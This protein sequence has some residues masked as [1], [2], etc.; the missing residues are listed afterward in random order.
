MVVRVL[1]PA[2][3]SLRRARDWWNAR[4]AQVRDRELAVLLSVLAF[5]PGFAAIGVEFGDL[6]VRPA[7]AFAVVLVLAQTVPLA[8]RTRLPAVCLAVSGLAFVVHALLGYPETFGGVG[9]Y[10]ALYAAGAY[11]RGYRRTLPLAATGCYAV[12]SVALHL[13]GSPQRFLDF[14]VFFAALCAFWGAGSYVRR[15]RAE[16]A[17]HRHSAALAA[18]AA[19]RARIARELHDVVTHHVTAMVVQADAAQFLSEQP[20]RVAEGLVA[21]GGTGRRAL[22]EL[23][24]LLGVLEATGESAS[25]ERSPTLGTVRELVERTRLG[26][27][28]V[29]LV[30]QGEHRKLGV[31][32]ELAVYRVVQEALTNAVKHAAGQH[33]VVRVGYGGDGVEIEVMSA[34]SGP[35][36]SASGGR[37]LRGLR[38]RVAMVGGELRAG[39]GPEGGFVVH[40]LIPAAGAR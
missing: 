29:E 39:P 35:G 38:E 30:E 9:F 23:R 20:D 21:I 25:A 11:Q 40:A 34:G 17:R 6:P 31:A 4:R 37:G 8:V 26:G 7:D 3:S 15:A 10:F 28:P 32:H 5:V 16:Q 2:V 12:F 24:D 18:T 27:Q 33:T 19:E 1:N 36:A 14:A 22:S 13:L